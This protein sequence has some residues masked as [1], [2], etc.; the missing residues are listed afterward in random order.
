VDH[1]IPKH[2]GARAGREADHELQSLCHRHHSAK[3]MREMRDPAG[4]STSLLLQK[5]LPVLGERS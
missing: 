5:T 1:V 3:T 2:P 4:R